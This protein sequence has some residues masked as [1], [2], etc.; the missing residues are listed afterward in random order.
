MLMVTRKSD[1]PVS[2]VGATLPV[3]G[4]T[5]VSTAWISSTGLACCLMSR[6]GLGKSERCNYTKESSGWQAVA[7]DDEKG[8]IQLN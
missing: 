4:Q 2:T 3:N 7:G 1:T 8:S 5:D 6:C